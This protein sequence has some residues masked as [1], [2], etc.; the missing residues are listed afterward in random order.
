MTEEEKDTN[1]RGKAS[2]PGHNGGAASE[3]GRANTEAAPRGMDAT[4]GASESGNNGGD[5]GTTSNKM[6][7]MTGFKQRNPD[8][9]DDDEEGFYGA[10]NDERDAWD[11]ERG[12][13][14]QREDEI[15]GAMSGSI[16]NAALFNEAM[17]G[18]PIPL[19]VLKRYPDEF[20]AWMDD[21]SNTDAIEKIFQEHAEAIAENKRLEEEA[22][23]NL[24]ETNATIDKMIED[25]ELKG[26]DEAN[27]LLKFLGEIA[28]GLMSNHVEKDWLIAAKKALHHDEDVD[29]ARAAGEIDGRNAKISAQRKSGQRGQ[30]THTGLGS[31]NAGQRLSPAEAR[32]ATGA[33][34]GRKSAWDGMKINKLN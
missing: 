12:A 34:G 3:S 2:E 31:G 7:Y 16:L 9:A 20:K 32:A 14:Q 6:K 22:Q 33:Q 13:Y 24:T 5:A 15:T 8:W 23:N 11:K 1:L 19:A 18:T 10:L 29:A 27:E 25:G 4:G 28:V 21:P 26:D 30:E 17:K